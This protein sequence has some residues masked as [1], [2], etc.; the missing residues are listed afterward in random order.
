MSIRENFFNSMMR[1]GTGFVG[2]DAYLCPSLFNEFK[3]RTGREDY[4]E[5][6]NFPVRWLSAKYTGSYD[7]FFKYHDGL[8]TGTEI[9]EWGVGYK[10]GVFK[11]FARMLHPMA[12]FK[13]IK[14][15]MD[16]PYPDVV[17]DYDWSGLQ[18]STEDVRAKDRI[19]IAAMQ[20]T[21][22]E[23]AWRMR[24]ME[25]FMVD[26]VEEPEI[27]AFHMDRISAIA[28]EKAGRYAKAGCDVL[29]LGDDVATQRGMM[30]NPVVWR[31]VLKPRLA[32]VIKTAKEI[33]PDMLIFYHSDGNM[34][35]IIP[36][37][38]DIG[39]EILNPV[40]PECMDPVKIK[41][42][43][44]DRLSFWGTLGTQTTMP[45]GTP[46]EV[47]KTCRKMI[48]EIGKGGGLFL[49][50]THILEPEVPW[51]NI[52]AYFETVREYNENRRTD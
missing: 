21:V 9:N 43:Y 37:L 49:A 3:D 17:N 31:D 26:M 15:Y 50:P 35:E 22:F 13:S 12:G 6:F 20:M 16:Y 40:Q 38:I 52:Y 14:D 47:R 36:E 2:Y 29:S 48:R 23:C 51:E 32:A 28:C 39:I 7:R 27:A 19:V 8:D 46:D 5:Y 44:G 25:D 41:K 4:A 45:F 33:K 11:H 34:E 42:E 1:R 24:G 10:R 30:L 18:K